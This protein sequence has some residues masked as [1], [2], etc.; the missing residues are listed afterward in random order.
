MIPLRRRLIVIIVPSLALPQPSYDLMRLVRSILTFENGETENC[1][2]LHLRF[3]NGNGENR[4]GNRLPLPRE[5]IHHALFKN[6]KKE[7]I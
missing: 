7:N 6:E 3:N 2:L 5:I 4:C 1:R